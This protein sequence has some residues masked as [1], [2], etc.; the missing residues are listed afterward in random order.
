M[1][2]HSYQRVHGSS[3]KHENKTKK[4]LL[5]EVEE[6]LRLVTGVR[7]LVHA[8]SGLQRRTIEIRSLIRSFNS[9]PVIGSDA[10]NGNELMKKGNSTG[11]QTCILLPLCESLQFLAKEA[12]GHIC[13]SFGRL[14]TRRLQR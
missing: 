13:L 2:K 10:I 9:R 12:Y 6:A 7:D 1:M 11:G 14:E 8:I 3:N 4:M 5:Q